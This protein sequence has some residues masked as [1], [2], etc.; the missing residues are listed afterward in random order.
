[1]DGSGTVGC[2]K[3]GKPKGRIRRAQCVTRTSGSALTQP[4]NLMMLSGFGLKVTRAPAR[5][6]VAIFL[7]KPRPGE[8][9]R[10]RHNCFYIE[11]RDFLRETCDASLRCNLHL[12]SRGANYSTR[13]R[14]V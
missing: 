5:M 4:A 14:R 10:K 9:R 7:P 12:Q 8:H 3:A 11:L 1:M 2:A 6:N 13:D